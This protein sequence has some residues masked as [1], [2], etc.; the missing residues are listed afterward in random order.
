[1]HNNT[2]IRPTS[3]QWLSEDDRHVSEYFFD[4]GFH[5]LQE[6]LD[7]RVFDLMNM[8]RI[9]AIRAEEIITCLYQ[10]LNPNT[11]EDQG[12]YQGLMEQQFDYQAWR[13][14]H[15]KLEN[16]TV[17]DLVLTE[18]IN[19]R[20]IQHFYDAIRKK[21]FKSDEYNSREYRFGNKAEYL[22]ELKKRQVEAT[23]E[24]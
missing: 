2:N 21:F 15:K 11:L 17:A 19:L 24:Q 6:I 8:N 9:N 12:M 14:V 5:S 13:K 16:I 22:A 20:A 1:M 18:N 4:L 23:N 10:Y 3:I 7:L